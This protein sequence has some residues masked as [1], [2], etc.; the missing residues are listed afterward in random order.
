MQFKDYK[1]VYKRYASL[2]F[3]VGVDSEEVSEGV[4]E[5]MDGWD[6]SRGGSMGSVKPPFSRKSCETK[7]HSFLFASC[8]LGLP[9]IHPESPGSGVSDIPDFKMFQGSTCPWTPLACRAFGTHKFKSPFAKSWI[10]PRL[11]ELM[12]ENWTTQNIYALMD[13][14]EAQLHEAE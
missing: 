12:N 1:V 7:F 4:D 11:D 8:S 10:R 6:G 9:S 3:I 2:Y 5:W 14:S 13:L